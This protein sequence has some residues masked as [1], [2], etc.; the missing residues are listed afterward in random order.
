METQSRLHPLFKEIVEMHTRMYARPM[1]EVEQGIQG[2]LS[3]ARSIPEGKRGV[4]Y[5]PYDMKPIEPEIGN[6]CNNGEGCD[7]CHHNEEA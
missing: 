2:E 7:N 3:H 4:D 1:N 6:A 5:C